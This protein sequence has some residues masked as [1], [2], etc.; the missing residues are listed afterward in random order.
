MN[1]ATVSLRINLVASY[2]KVAKRVEVTIDA[3]DLLIDDDDDKVAE[4]LSP[5]IYPAMETQKNMLFEPNMYLA[6]SL[7]SSELDGVVGFLK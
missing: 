3:I 1:Q 5:F 2:D 7:L 4:V 6:S